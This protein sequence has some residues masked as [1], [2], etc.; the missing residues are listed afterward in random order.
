MGTWERSMCVD[1]DSFP[2]SSIPAAASSIHRRGSAL[3]LGPQSQRVSMGAALLL[4][5][6]V[7]SRSWR[8]TCVAMVHATHL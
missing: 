5:P 4:V 3:P 8:D 6:S 1:A 2:S 7:L